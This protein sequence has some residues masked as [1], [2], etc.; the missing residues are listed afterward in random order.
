MLE[1][2]PRVADIVESGEKQARLV[3]GTHAGFRVMDLTSNLVEVV[4]WS[5]DLGKPVQVLDVGQQSGLM[6]LCYESNS[7][8]IDGST[9]CTNV[10][11]GVMCMTD[12]PSVE[13]K[14]FM[15]RQ[16]PLTFVAKMINK[17]AP[18]SAEAMPA[19]NVLLVAGSATMVD[20]W[21]LDQARIVHIFETR[22]DRIKSLDLLCVRDETRLLLLAGE[23]KDGQPCSSV[24]CIYQDDDRAAATN[25]MKASASHGSIG[26]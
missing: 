1:T 4:P 5:P 2:T 15:W 24:I 6:V 26:Q 11:C 7:I 19:R 23:E 20:I 8:S 14:R 16:T 12:R 22:K 3:I 13:M 18:F 17:Y 21:S 10:D 25:S 9:N